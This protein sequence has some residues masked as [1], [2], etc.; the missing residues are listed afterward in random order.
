MTNKTH[1]I[2]IVGAVIEAKERLTFRYVVGKNMKQMT[3]VLCSNDTQLTISFLNGVDLEM[4][5]LETMFVD[6]LDLPPNTRILSWDQD[7][8]QCRV[9]VGNITNIKSTAQYVSLYLLT[10]KNE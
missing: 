8:S 7:L 2:R 4:N 10:Y 1:I 9:I 3:G 6:S 5:S